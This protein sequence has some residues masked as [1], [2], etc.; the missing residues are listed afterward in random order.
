VAEKADENEVERFY[1]R[2]S[3][4]YDEQFGELAA[5]TFQSGIKQEL[6]KLNIQSGRVVDV[7]A[8]TGLAKKWLSE[9]GVFEYFGIEPSKNIREYSL[10][11]KK[12]FS[13]TLDSC[14]AAQGQ[15]FD[16]AMSNF[17]T[18]NLFKPDQL[19]DLFSRLADI[20]VPKGYFLFDTVI[21]SRDFALKEER[22]AYGGKLIIELKSMGLYRA[23]TSVRFDAGDR[24]W[25][26]A[27]T[28]Y[29]YEADFLVEKAKEH[30]WSLSSLRKFRVSQR[31]PKKQSFSLC[32]DIR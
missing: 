26:V 24:S 22:S 2:I 30:G 13:S 21:P 7:G 31:D 15:S 6:L 10:L 12:T 5:N 4:I 1:N 8:G 18:L 11:P 32:L 14:A 25:F 28:H 3:S 23:K 16:L 27:H 20:V 29:F 19:D 9:L 17:D